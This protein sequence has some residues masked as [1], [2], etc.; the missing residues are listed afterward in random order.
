M[1][2]LGNDLCLALEA[3]FELRVSMQEFGWQNLDSHLALEA[4]IVSM[5]DSCHAPASQ[6]RFDFVTSDFFRC[7]NGSSIPT[8]K[9]ERKKI[10]WQVVNSLYEYF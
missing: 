9:R 6:F 10:A 7:H 4:R 5:I 3:Q 1:L 2:Q 8:Q